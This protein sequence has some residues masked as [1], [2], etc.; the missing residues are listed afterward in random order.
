VLKNRGPKPAEGLLVRY[1]VT[2]RLVAPGAAAGAAGEWAVPFLVDERRVAKIPPNK[3]LEVPLQLSP[4]LDIYLKRMTREGFRVDR[5]K[6]SAMLEP[7][8]AQAVVVKD[9][10]LEISP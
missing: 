2:A 7:Q 8:K 4:V 9:A 10:E 1:S 3:V 5:L 6:L